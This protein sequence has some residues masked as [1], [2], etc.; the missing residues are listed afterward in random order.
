MVEEAH[1][2]EAL[3][4]EDGQR[5]VIAEIQQEVGIALAAA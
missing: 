1:L 5:A 4:V 2:Q 3:L